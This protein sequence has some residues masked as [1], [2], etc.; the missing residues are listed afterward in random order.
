[1]NGTVNMYTHLSNP[2]KVNFLV[3]LASRVT[4]SEGK[5]PTYGEDFEL[6]LPSSNRPRAE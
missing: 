4:D 2:S 5:T 3:Q 6:W 1:M